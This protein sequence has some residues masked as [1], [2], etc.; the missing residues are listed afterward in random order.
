MHF[1]RFFKR[2]VYYYPW[3]FVGSIAGGAAGGGFI[4]GVEAQTKLPFG[5]NRRR[6]KDGFF[7]WVLFGAAFSGLFVTTLPLTV[8]MYGLGRLHGIIKGLKSKD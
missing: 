1:L 3:V 2:A 5:H 6:S 7:D 4:A 8:P